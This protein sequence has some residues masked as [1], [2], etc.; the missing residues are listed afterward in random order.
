[1]PAVLDQPAPPLA[2]PDAT[3][4]PVDLADHRGEHVVVLFFYPKSFTP[5][6]TAESCAFRDAYEAFTDAGAVVVGVSSDDAAT[7]ARFAEQHRL[8]FTL[9]ADVGG[10]ARAAWGVPRTLGLLPGRVTYVIDRDGIVRH[11][12]S[13]QLQAT[14]HVREALDVVARLVDPDGDGA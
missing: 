10:R 8:P 13:S 6:C 5:G 14:R 12:F 4:K 1:M 9:L 3:G 7:Q 2:L 11:V